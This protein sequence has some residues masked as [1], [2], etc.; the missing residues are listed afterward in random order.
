MVIPRAVTAETDRRKYLRSEDREGEAPA[1]PQSRLGRSLALP[2][3]RS[4]FLG[5]V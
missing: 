3:A 1:E 4:L 5:S 2:N